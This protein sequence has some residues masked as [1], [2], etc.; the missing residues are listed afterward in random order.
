MRFSVVIDKS[1]VPYS[2]RLNL[3]ALFQAP[4][5]PRRYVNGLSILK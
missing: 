5:R 4:P 1:M 3:E 2:P